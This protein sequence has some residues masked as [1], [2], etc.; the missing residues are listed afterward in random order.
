MY[1]FEGLLEVQRKKKKQQPTTVVFFFAAQNL[2][3]QT[4]TQTNNWT[5]TTKKP[6][7]HAECVQFCKYGETDLM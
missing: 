1:L 3:L 2:C 4:Q 6:Q 5:K 7:K